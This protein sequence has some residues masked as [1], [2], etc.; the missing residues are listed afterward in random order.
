[1]VSI[2]FCYYILGTY[3]YI[4]SRHDS[5]HYCCNSLR[6][7]D[8][9]S[10]SWTTRVF[11]NI[12]ICRSGFVGGYGIITTLVVLTERWVINNETIYK[13]EPFLLLLFNWEV[14]LQRVIVFKRRSSCNFSESYIL[15]PLDFD[16]IG[17]FC[18]APRY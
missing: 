11:S 14:F 5:T 6:T 8:F 13:N 9:V 4:V 10:S 7:Y 18:S 16:Y 17:N 15:K 1:M 3:Y 12:P 2:Y